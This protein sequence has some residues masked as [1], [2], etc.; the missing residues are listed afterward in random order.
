MSGGSVGRDAYSG[1]REREL[2]GIRRGGRHCDLDAAHG[3]ADQG[4]NLQQLEADG[5][6][7]GVGEP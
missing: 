7:C 1:M 2:L 3:D 4:C 5:A 6:A